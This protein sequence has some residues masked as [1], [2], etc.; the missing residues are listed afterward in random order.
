M[1]T[2]TELIPSAEDWY[3]NLTYGEWVEVENGDLQR[4]CHPVMSYKDALAA[5]NALVEGDSTAMAGCGNAAG[6]YDYAVHAAEVASWVWV[7]LQDA[8]AAYHRGDTDAV[9]S[10]LWDASVAERECGEDMATQSLA[11]RILVGG[12]AELRRLRDH[13]GAT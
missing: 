7:S 12:Y 10:F 8:V 4:F 3:N 1:P 9:V 11:N 6:L 13:G 2:E 5:C